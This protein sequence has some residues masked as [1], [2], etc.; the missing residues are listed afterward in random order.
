MSH[1]TPSSAM[2]DRFD[3]Q[4]GLLTDLPGVLKTRP[5]TI[6]V[7]PPLGIGGAEYFTVQTVRMRDEHDDTGKTIYVTFLIVAGPQGYHRLVL[8]HEVTDVIIRQRDSLS[9]TA[10]RQT[11]RRLATERAARGEQ[12]GFMKGKRKRGTK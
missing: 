7:I 4:M 1:E 9:T 3:R 6:D 12:P 2:P 5:S 8:P 11:G 10:K